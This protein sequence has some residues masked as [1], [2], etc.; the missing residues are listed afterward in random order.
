MPRA[1]DQF[2]TTEQV[3]EY[4]RLN[5]KTVYRLISAGKLPAIRV[6]HQWRFRKSD[7]DAWL[8][9]NATHAR[10][11]V[12]SA[13]SG[14]R[15]SV[16]VVDDDEGARKVVAAALGAA[17]RFDVAVAEDGPSALAMLRA[18]QFD[19][20]LFDL[21]MPGMDG[22]TLAREARQLTPGLA[23]VILTAASTETSAIDAVNLGV[24]AYILK[25]F[26]ANEIIDAMDRALARRVG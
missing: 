19:A 5:L 22:I 3:L 14:D 4:L 25:P 8:A 17:G 6:G 13:D 15:A 1:D 24:A 26:R 12:P 11:P 10:A 7:L 20:L 16:L 18:Q 2:L 21:K 23:L 9:S